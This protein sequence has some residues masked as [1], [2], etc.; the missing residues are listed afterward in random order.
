MLNC[1]T[2]EDF[3]EDIREG[4]KDKAAQMRLQT[5]K[6]V[7]QCISKKDKRVC[8]GLKSLTLAIVETTQDG[9]S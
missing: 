6:F 3:M 8:N 4:M 9:S 1:I 7:F 5:L 2:F